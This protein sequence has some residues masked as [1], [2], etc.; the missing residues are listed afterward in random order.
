MRKRIVYSAL[1]VA[2]AVL[3]AAIAIHA[4]AGASPGGGPAASAPA[5]AE[6][7]ICAAG[8]VEPVSEAIQIGSQ[9]PGVLREVN[10]DEGQRVAKGAAIASVENGDFRARVA[11]AGATVALRQAELDRLVNGAREQERREAASAVEEAR[12]VLANAKSEMDRRRP[13]FQ[14]GDISRSDWERTQREFDVAEAR[15]S[16]AS[17]HYAFVNAPARADELARAAAAVEL[18]RAQLAETQALLEK[19]VVR[20]PFAG[21]VLKRYRKA[22]ETVSDKG[23]TPIVSFGDNSRLRVRVDVDETDV[24]K[25][26]VGD[27]AYFTAAAFGDRRFWGRVARIGSELG[28]KNVATGQPAEK[29]DTKILET[30]VDLDGHPPLPPGLRVDSFIQIGGR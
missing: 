28:Q 5:A 30:L 19:T 27:R 12:A 22:G 20:A 17:Q 13:L 2:G 14:S 23:D 1:V 11:Q 15:L 7:F 9:I 18:A 3:G 21:T 10:V 6:N 29:L 16:Q 8:R 25:V 24:A 26:S 4:R